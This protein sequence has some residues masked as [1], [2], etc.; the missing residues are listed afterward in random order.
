MLDTQCLAILQAAAS[1]TL[2]LVI[3]TNNPAKARQALY[4]VRKDFGDATMA[5]LTIRA[6]PD[7]ANTKLWIFRR[8]AVAPTIDLSAAGG[9]YA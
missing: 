2:G 8:T 9:S 3:H 5:E 6:A 1:S 7:D 4:R